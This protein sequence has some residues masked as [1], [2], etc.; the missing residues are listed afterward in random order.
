MCATIALDVFHEPPEMPPSFGLRRR[1]EA[2]SPLRVGPRL[3]RSATALKFG[4]SESGE[5]LRASQHSKAPTNATIGRA[6]LT[7]SLTLLMTEWGG[8]V[9]MTPLSIQE[10]AAQSPLIVHG[11]VV[12]KS[13]HRDPA[14]RIY[15]KVE[16]QLIDVWKGTPANNPLTIVHGGG[17]LGGEQVVVAAQVE[18]NL[19]EE[20]VAFLVLNQRGEAVTL[21]LAQGKFHVWQDRTTGDVLVRNPF[22]GAYST[23]TERSRSAGSQASAPLTLQALK[24]HVKKEEK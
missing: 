20:V 21:G 24:S 3:C 10:L 5:S 11:T 12:N 17:T 22:H 18:Y 19:R 2:P 14:G 9:I 15:T 8:A 6:F 16:L 23:P 13:C 7:L 1:S 4:R